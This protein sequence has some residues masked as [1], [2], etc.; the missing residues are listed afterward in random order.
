MPFVWS[1]GCTIGPAIGGFLA[2]PVE[3]FPHL[4]G[5]STVLAAYP[6][7][8]PNLVCAGMLALT[9]PLN[10]LFLDETHPQKRRKRVLRVTSHENCGYEGAEAPL[11]SPTRPE[12]GYDVPPDVTPKPGSPAVP[13]IK[14]IPARLWML[15]LAVCILNIHTLSF[16]QNFPIFL[17]TPRYDRVPPQRFWAGNGGLG[18]SLQAI[19]LIMLINGIIGLVVQALV[20]PPMAKYLGTRPY[21]L[22]ISIIYPLGYFV[23]PY[24]AFISPGAW[25]TFG[26]YFWL[27][28]RNIFT[29]GAYPL[30]L[31]FIK[32]ATP[33]P[34][35]LGR[36]NG[37]MVSL[38]AGC[39]TLA[40][41]VAG[42]LQNLGEKYHVSALAWW[43][44][45]VEALLGA[46]LACL[47]DLPK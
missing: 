5:T 11:L 12:H 45:G 27:T 30:I 44:F 41:P 47:I 18:L 22:L 10:C 17:Q 28:V 26:I 38:T 9:M 20:F 21:F 14:D 35:L 6:Y 23:L 15:I 36:V 25:L 32:R 24:M 40:P 1:L 39:R 13:S 37:L 46:L 16:F 8:L 19:G 2:R 33:S 7:L 42:F 31:I 3:A 43:G 4:F 29:T 34:L